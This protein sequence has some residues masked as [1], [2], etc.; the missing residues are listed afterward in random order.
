[1]GPFCCPSLLLYTA[2]IYFIHLQHHYLQHINMKNMGPLCFPWLLV[3]AAHQFYSMQPLF[4]LYTPT[5]LFITFYWKT[6]AHSAAQDFY[7]MQPLFVFYIHLFTICNISMKNMVQ[8]CCPS[9]WSPYLFI[10][11]TSLS[12]TFSWKTWPNLLPLL[13]LSAAPIYCTPITF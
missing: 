3:Y 12:G 10:H 11:P 9:L 1:M 6:W 7:S 2:P 13:L 4:N 8:F 5:S